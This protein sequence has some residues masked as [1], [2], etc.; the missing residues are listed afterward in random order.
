MMRV[1]VSAVVSLVFFAVVTDAY[2]S[3]AKHQLWRLRVTNNE[4]VA[5]ILEFSR[6]AHLHDINFWT[7]EFRMN[8]PV[9]FP[10]KKEE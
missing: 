5:K 8:I 9:R 3:Y 10:R 6:S 7:E 2:K 1:W 4:Q